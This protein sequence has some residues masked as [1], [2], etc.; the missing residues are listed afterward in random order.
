MARSGAAVG[1]GAAAGAQATIEAVAKRP[2]KAE[3]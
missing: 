2:K 1:A 3:S